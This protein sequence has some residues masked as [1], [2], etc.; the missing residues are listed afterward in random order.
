MRD[1]DRATL[2]EAV[3][4]RLADRDFRKRLTATARD[5]SRPIIVALRDDPMRVLLAKLEGA[6]G[7]GNVVVPAFNG[8]LVVSMTTETLT[9][10]APDESEVDELTADCTVGV[11][12]ERLTI[13]EGHAWYRFVVKGRQRGGAGRAGVVALGG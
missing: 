5:G 10:T 4:R 7:S 11:F 1:V 8:F 3:Y 12:M 13:D 6:G 2:T 9:E